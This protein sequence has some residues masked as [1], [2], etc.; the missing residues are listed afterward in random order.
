M[1][2]RSGSRLDAR[3]ASVLL[4]SVALWAAC[5][6][7]THAD[8]YAAAPQPSDN[9]LCTLCASRPDLR[10]PPC[11]PT[12]PE[13]AGDVTVVFAMRALDLGIRAS[14][15]QSGYLVGFDQDCSDRPD[16]VPTSCTA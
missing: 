8:E 7:L 1:T 11:G 5:T 15:W 4:P 6:S 13:P 14:G 2:A 16:G 9:P 10:H 12:A 3:W